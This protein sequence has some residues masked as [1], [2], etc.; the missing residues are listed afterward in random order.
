MDTCDRY[1]LHE[2]YK[3]TIKTMVKSFAV[4]LLQKMHEGLPAEEL[5]SF[6]DEWVDDHIRAARFED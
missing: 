5:I 2:M 3:D 1:A 4:D 6:C